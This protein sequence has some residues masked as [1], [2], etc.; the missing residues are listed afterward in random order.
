[1]NHFNGEYFIY[2]IPIP[3]SKRVE[4][5]LPILIVDGNGDPKTRDFPFPFLEAT[6]SMSHTQYALRIPPCSILQPFNFDFMPNDHQYHQN[7]HY[8][9]SII[10]IDM[11]FIISNTHPL[12]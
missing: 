12:R 6:C 4:L 9:P 3:M 8:P 2:Y 7:D 1:L 5:K 10:P 11:I